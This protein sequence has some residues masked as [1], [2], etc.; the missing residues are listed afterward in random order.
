M[1]FLKTLL[2]CCVV[3]LLCIITNVSRALLSA[4]VREYHSYEGEKLQMTR[5]NLK[6]LNRLPLDCASFLFVISKK[7][8]V[9]TFADFR[10]QPYY[11]SMFISLCY[12]EKIDQPFPSH[13][14]HHNKCRSDAY[15]FLVRNKSPTSAIPWCAW[16]TTHRGQT[17]F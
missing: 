12:A 2:F 16:F 3:L 7:Q 15:L 9:K 13:T 11:T 1:L 17:Y 4:K 14:S 6:A 5:S 8:N 10:V